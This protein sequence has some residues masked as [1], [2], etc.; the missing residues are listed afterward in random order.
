MGFPGGGQPSRVGISIR[1]Q[2]L[3][4]KEELEWGQWRYQRGGRRRCWLREQG[5]E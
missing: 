1:M 5:H 2:G 4:K 3:K